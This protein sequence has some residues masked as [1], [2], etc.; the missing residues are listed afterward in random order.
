MTTVSINQRRCDRQPGCPARRACPQAA[1]VPDDG[2]YIVIE[3]KCTGCGVCT[4]V[5]PMNAVSFR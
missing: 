4:R 5:C 2:G 1:I 3:D